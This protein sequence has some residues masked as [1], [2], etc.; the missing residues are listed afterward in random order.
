MSNRGHYHLSGYVR[1][2]LWI[3][4]KRALL[5]DLGL[6]A[7]H[8]EEAA[9]EELPLLVE[10]ALQVRDLGVERGVGLGERGLRGV[11][12][13]PQGAQQGVE[14][15]RDRKSTRLNSSHT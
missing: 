14:L 8:R 11:V 7:F 3:R 4:S 13:I 1:V 9:R 15:G 5:L 12:R 6:G 10:P 2:L